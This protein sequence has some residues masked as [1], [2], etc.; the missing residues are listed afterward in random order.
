MRRLI[1][2]GVALGVAG[3]GPA[4]TGVGPSA[5][6]HPTMAATAAPRPS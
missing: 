4:A 6:A 1:Y 3:C 5:T 2:L